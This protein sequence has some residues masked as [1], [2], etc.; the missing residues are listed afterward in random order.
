MKRILSCSQ[1]DDIWSEHFSNR[2]R[3]KSP[4]SIDVI[5]IVYNFSADVSTYDW[6]WWKILVLT[7]IR[8]SWNGAS[9]KRNRDRKYI[10]KK[11]LRNPFNIY[12][13]KFKNDGVKI[14]SRLGHFSRV[15]FFRSGSEVCHRAH[16]IVRT[17]VCRTSKQIWFPSYIGRLVIDLL[18][19]I[20]SRC[21]TKAQT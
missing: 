20:R 7:F 13:V 9:R 5:D 17:D 15:V 11:S 21:I 18:D 4:Q 19:T 8:Y 14:R 6:N 16:E 1:C 3:V 2:V 12:D 10:K